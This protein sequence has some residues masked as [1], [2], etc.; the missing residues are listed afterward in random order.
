MLFGSLGEGNLLYI[1]LNLFFALEESEEA[2]WRMKDVVCVLKYRY[3]FDIEKDL[4][5]FF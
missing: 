2:S 5:I 4:G 1:F 3:P